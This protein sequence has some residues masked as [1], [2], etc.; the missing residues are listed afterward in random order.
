MTDYNPTELNVENHINGIRQSISDDVGSILSSYSSKAHGFFAVPRLLFP[1]IDGLGSYLT[2]QPKETVLNITTYFKLVL[3]QLDSRYRKYAV[4]ITLIYRHGL[5]HQHT[6][7]EFEYKH[8]DIGWI[9]SINSPNNPLDVQ[10]KYHLNFVQN[11]LQLDMNVFYSDVIESTNILKKMIN[12]K[13]RDNY[14][15]SVL[16]Q[17][18]PLNKTKILK[19][20]K[21]SKFIKQSDFDFFKEL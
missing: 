2:G 7:K 11:H 18:T 21:D 6:P 13:Y 8:K 20:Y 17:K 4:F 1:E 10:R 3:S 19:N 15:K 14:I 5:L 9:F 16:I 12:D